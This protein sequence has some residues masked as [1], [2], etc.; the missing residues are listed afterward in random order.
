MVRSMRKANFRVS[1]FEI[2]TADKT[3]RTITFRV[4]EGFASGCE[5]E[6]RSEYEMAYRTFAGALDIITGL[7]PSAL[8]VERWFTMVPFEGVDNVEG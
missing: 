7:K 6:A 4:R 3:D 8:A 1:D 5:L 2:C